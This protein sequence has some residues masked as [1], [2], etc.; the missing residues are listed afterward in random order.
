MDLTLVQRQELQVRIPRTRGDGPVTPALMEQAVKDSPHPRGWTLVGPAVLADVAG[1]PAP[2]GMDLLQS[3][4]GIWPL[5]IPRT[6]GDGPRSGG[7]TISLLKDSPHPRGWTPGKLAVHLHEGG[8]PAPAGMDPTLY[9][10][11]FS[12]RRIPRTRGDGPE[13]VITGGGVI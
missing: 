6:R 8:F 9:R 13:L 2:A 4:L 5:R 10:F 1:F 3:T 12:R 7:Q 11:C